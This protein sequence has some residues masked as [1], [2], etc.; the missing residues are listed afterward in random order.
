MSNEQHYNNTL[1]EGYILD[2][3]EIIRVLGVG[4]FGIAYLA[5]DT[6]FDEECV[7]KEYM[8]NAFA[9]RDATVGTVNPSGANNAD[10]YQWGLNEFLNEAKTV[11]KCQHQNIV[12]VIRFFEANNTA[13]IV[14][15]YIEGNN[16]SDL[17]KKSGRKTL[18]EAEIK[19]IVIPLLEGLQA[20]H[21]KNIFHRDIK[22]SNIYIY[23]HDKTPI[24]I[25]FGS[26][27]FSLG[28]HS[29]SLTTILTPG[30]SPHEQ[31]HRHGKQ[32]AWTDI[33]AMGAVMYCLISGNKPPEAP[34]RV[35]DDPF[36]PAIEVGKGNYSAHFLAAIDAALAVKEADRPQSVA[37]LLQT[38]KAEADETRVYQ[39]AIQSQPLMATKAK[40][41]EK[42]AAEQSQKT[43][44]KLSTAWIVMLLLLIPILAVSA[45]LFFANT[46]HTNTTNNTP[47]V[48]SAPSDR[49]MDTSDNT[50]INNPVTIKPPVI[51]P[52]EAKEQHTE[53]IKT[54]LEAGRQ[55][56]LKSQFEPALVEYNKVIALDPQH[57]RAFRYKGYALYRLSDYS[58]A[59]T[60]LSRADDIE[61]GNFYNVLNL[62]KAYCALDQY[63][64]INGLI[65]QYK[66][67]LIKRKKQLLGDGELKKVCNKAVIARYLND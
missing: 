14:M 64:A 28:E 9:Y 47:S 42:E 18:A 24:L 29:R 4:G 25:D 41:E 36:I 16:L 1:P 38:L 61:P 45:R 55:Y 5:K 35:I 39:P 10:I 51:V 7:I 11:K 26:A 34:A 67:T 37:Q 17:L 63:N 49:N 3:F 30:Y 57:A 62:I 31:Y 46:D 44:K 20:V 56:A 52:R 43:T 13:Y 15:P 59:M 66:D 12:E 23:T 53:T 2:N 6:Y 50:I 22:P 40:E 48:I 8:P 60:A 58:Q 32:G 27:R 65:N 21:E 33:Y 54:T 19:A